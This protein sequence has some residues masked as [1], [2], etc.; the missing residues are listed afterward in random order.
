MRKQDKSIIIIILAFICGMITVAVLVAMVMSADAEVDKSYVE[1]KI[2]KARAEIPKAVPMSVK[3]QRQT[4][5]P[6]VKPTETP[7]LTQKPTEEPKKRKKQKKQRVS[8]ADIY[9]LAQVISAENGSAKDDDCLVLTGIVVMKR[10]KSKS[11]PNTIN[12]VVSAKGQYSTY[13]RLLSEKPSSRCLEIAEEILR[14]NL[15]KYYPNKLVFQSE[16]PQGRAVYR[17]IGHEYF[18]LAN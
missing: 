9:R 2:A 6:T 4:T 17:K 18:C 1:K 11:F 8:D 14:E 13:P 5:E 7:K 16:F 3:M 12:G 15:Q 10:V